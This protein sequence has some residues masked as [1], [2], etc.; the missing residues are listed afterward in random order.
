VK[1]QKR[2]VLVS[3]LPGSGKSTLARRLAPALSLRLIDKD[4]ILDRLFG[5]KGIGNGEWRS[6]LSRESDGILQREAASSD[7]AVLTSFWWL[8]GMPASSGT[9]TDWLSTLSNHLV[10]VNCICAPEIAAERFLRRRRHPGHLDGGKS[11]ADILASIQRLS[12][13]GPLD[14]GER[15]DADTSREPA[16]EVVVRDIRDAFERCRARDRRHRR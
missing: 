12:D 3:G 7:G 14:V 13:L 2:F 16:L 4:E 5:S 15:V 8:P 1:T 11:H 10:N 9:P 6:R